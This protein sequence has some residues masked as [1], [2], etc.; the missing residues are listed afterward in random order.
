MFLVLTPKNDSFINKYIIKFINSFCKPLFIFF[1]KIFI[2][3]FLHKN[4]DSIMIIFIETFKKIS[5]EIIFYRA[6]NVYIIFIVQKMNDC[7][8]LNHDNKKKENLSFPFYVYGDW[9]RSSK[10]PDNVCAHTWVK[11]KVI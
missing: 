6:K 7:Y 3:Y 4:V 1:L 9:I 10:A 11:Q 8:N 5:I 2:W